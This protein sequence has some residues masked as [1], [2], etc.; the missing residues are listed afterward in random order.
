[1]KLLI[2]FFLLSSVAFGQYTRIKGLAPSYVGKNIE[3]YGYKDF[4]TMKQELLGKTTV[5]ADS[6]FQLVL[7]LDGI[8]KVS[9]QSNNNKGSMYLQENGNYDIYFPEKD[10]FDPYRPTGNLVEIAFFEL[11]STDINYKI[12]SFERWMD[13][14]VGNYFYIK[15]A[16]PMEFV[17]AL[18]RFKSNVEK[19]YKNDS[20]T[21]FKTYV[22]FRIA[23]LD[24]IQHAA[25]RNRYEKH[26]FYIKTSPVSYDNDAYMEY[27]NGFYQDFM[28]RLSN[29]TNQAVYEGVLAE[30]PT[31][32]M[33][34]LGTEYTMLNV[35]IRELIMMKSLAEVYFSGDYPQTNI[36]TILDSV[37][38]HA[39][40]EAHKDIAANLIDRLTELV[41]GGAAPDFSIRSDD[42]FITLQNFS[43]KHLY[44]HFFDPSSKTSQKELLLLIDLYKKYASSVEF[45]S[46]YKLGTEGDAEYKALR[47]K[48]TWKV[49]G[50]AADNPI[51]KKYKVESF[52]SYTLLDA[53]GYV[54][55]SPA[56]APTPNGQYQ[57][58]DET[59]FN[60][61][62]IRLNQNQPE[63]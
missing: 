54:V 53:A 25:E 10:K 36:M 39:L 19:A 42:A 1:M 17:E 52:P 20:S 51:W 28:P 34:A 18:D 61:Q 3:V 9:I 4:L 12:L 23:S 35:R 26:D 16:K 63:R 59:L 30:S 33:Q 38:H 24:N 58:I 22:K 27:I 5:N 32:I 44:I 7:E 55:M 47:E 56:L 29:Q 40:F 43:G 13:N 50:V 8:R 60:I 11:D 48:M 62:K 2:S 41:P 31:L 14:F 37:Q 21:Y 45:L 6:S 15:D 46:L 57:T 49:I